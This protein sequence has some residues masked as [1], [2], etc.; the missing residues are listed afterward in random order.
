MALLIDL[1]GEIYKFELSI[2]K[3]M[4]LGA[5]RHVMVTSL[6]KKP[7]TQNPVPRT[8]NLIIKC[9]KINVKIDFI[10]NIE[11]PILSINESPV[12]K[13]PII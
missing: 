5:G 12:N 11:I 6:S 1:K 10:K 13:S 7:T 9:K 2:N 8:Q 3:I 4:L